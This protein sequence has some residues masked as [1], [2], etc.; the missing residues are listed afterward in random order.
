[1]DQG[2][3]EANRER[4]FCKIEPERSF[5]FTHRLQRAND[6]LKYREADKS[7]GEF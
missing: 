5:G 3:S 6:V 4:I 1:V 7:E 2:H